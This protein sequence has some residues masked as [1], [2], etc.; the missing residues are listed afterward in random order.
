MAVG[1]GGTAFGP[2]GT[3][4]R[5]GGTAFTP[6]G[7]AIGHAGQ[8]L[9]SGV[10]DHAVP[11]DEVHLVQLKL[12]VGLVRTDPH[13]GMAAPRLARLAAVIGADLRVWR[14]GAS[15]SSGVIV[16]GRHDVGN[17]AGRPCRQHSCNCRADRSGVTKSAT[18]TGASRARR[19]RSGETGPARTTAL[20]L[21]SSCPPKSSRPP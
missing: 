2:G 15:P 21:M 5:H 9:L 11:D 8:Q 1:P 19:P 7:T 17:C 14:H 10:H 13:D 6:G 20:P 4:F 16:M 12:A 18:V 3:A